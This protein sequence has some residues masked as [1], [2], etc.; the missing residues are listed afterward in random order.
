MKTKAHR[1]KLYSIEQ[2]YMTKYVFIWF[3]V[4]STY[5]EGMWLWTRGGAAG[6]GA[7]R[8]DRLGMQV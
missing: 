6:T 5:E 1:W 3:T 7:G 8:Q 4:V 2:F